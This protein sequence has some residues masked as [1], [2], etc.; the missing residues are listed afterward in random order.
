MKQVYQSFNK[1]TL[2]VYDVPSPSIRPG[3]LI[4]KNNAS[5]ISMG[6]ESMVTDFGNKNI[7][8]K[9]KARP[10]LVKQVLDKV[11]TDGLVQ[12]IHTAR[13]SLDNPIALGYSCAGIVEDVDKSIE[14]FSIGMPVA[15]AGA[16][17]AVHAEQ[18]LV[19][20]NL[21]VKIPQNV[22]LEHAAFTTIGSI[23]MQGYR[24][25]NTQIGDK[26]AVMG[27]GLIG[28]LMVQILKSA[29]C[30]VIAYDPKSKQCDLA[31][32]LG[33]DLVSDNQDIFI[34]KCLGFSDGIGLDNVIITAS[35]KSNQPIEVAGLVTRNK[36]KVVVVGAV[37][38]DMPRKNYYE[39]ELDLVVSKSYGPG[40][41]DPLYEEGGADY[42]I[43]YVRWTE[44]RNMQSFLSL[45]S[46]RKV[47]LDKI[48]T[49]RFSI[50]NAVDAYKLLE[51]KSNNNPIGIIINYPDNK[52]VDSKKVKFFDHKISKLKNSKVKI[53]IIGAGGFAS[54]TLIPNINKMGLEKV[55]ICNYNSHS[56]HHK[57]KKFGF[58]YCTTDSNQ[59]IQD[60]DINTVVISTRHNTHAEYV[61][62]ALNNNKNIF[63]EK[64]LAL[65]LNQ[66]DDIELALKKSKASLMIGFNRRFSPL[67][68]KMKELRE[69]QGG[70]IS[71]T[72]TI[73]A[74]YLP[75]DHWTQDLKIGGGRIKGEV[76]HFID[77][78]RFLVG[79]EFSSSTIKC[80]KNSKTNDTITIL[81]SFK[82]GSIANINYF[83]NGSKKF[84]KERVELYCNESILQLDN[85]RSLNGYGWPG[86]DTMSLR[87]QDKGHGK[88][89]QL[90]FDSIRNG[91]E[92]PISIAELLEVSRETIILAES[93]SKNI[94]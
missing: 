82:D 81:L 30:D 74:G 26:V 38:M 63:V 21:V 44:N 67:S 90:F 64:P 89:L 58:N 91:S 22:E 11:K 70:P 20:R 83:S 7:I 57:A 40:R 46:S 52:F 55:G 65:F 14:N 15:C 6:T 41:Y 13:A 54:H 71:I 48:I 36:A 24:L 33:A 18:I 19:P 68:E 8:Q 78:A 86:F 35:T 39:K 23:A 31:D 92:N 1:N 42:P 76:C 85:F 80:M 17:Y 10:D 25:S 88:E 3:M 51:P 32:D 47:L 2:G 53:G 49:H 16:G 77:F 28:L 79:C 37:G 84:P 93:L 45:L 43:G 5:V 72:M 61:L 66:I 75:H 59:I 29:G 69:K 56:A 9:A 50:E 60:E 62:D 94:N 12:T 4:I 87:R 27:L 34:K 73:N